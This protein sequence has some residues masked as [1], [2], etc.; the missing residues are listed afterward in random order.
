MPD[1]AEGQGAVTGL[2]IDDV[3]RPVPDGLILLQGAGLTATTDERG[4][5]QFLGVLPGS[6]IA[7]AT[8]KDHEAAPVNI[9]VRAGEYA[10]LEMQARRIFSQDGVVITTQYSVFVPCAVSAVAGSVSADCTGDQ[11]GDTFRAGFTANYTGYATATYLVTEMKA[12]HK[13]SPDQG[14]FKVVVRE[15]GNGDYWA[16]KYTVDSDY[17]KLTMLMGNV[18]TDDTEARNAAWENDK[19]METLLFP[20]GAVK[21]ESQG[22]L[23]SACSTTNSTGHPEGCFE[24]RGVGPQAGV[25]ATFVQSLFLGPPAVDVGEYHVLAPAA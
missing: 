6:Y 9:D 14:A 20:Q 4:Q 25:K 11:S 10:E 5:F 7:L 24:S 15:E 16:S 19:H 22:G 21:G 1:L 13:A 3:Y 8:A 18:S 23:D 2:L 12:N 17:L